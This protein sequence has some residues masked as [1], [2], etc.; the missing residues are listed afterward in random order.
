MNWLFNP[1]YLHE[2]ENSETY[3]IGVSLLLYTARWN[4]LELDVRTAPADDVTQIVRGVHRFVID[5]YDNIADVY[6][7]LLV[8]GAAR[9]YPNNGQTV[10]VILITHGYALQRREYSKT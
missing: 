4:D 8:G 10:R 5:L 2:G 9:C 3:L 7:A 6:E 1:D